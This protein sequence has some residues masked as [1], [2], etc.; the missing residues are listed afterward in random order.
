VQ[1]G[2]DPSDSNI[3]VEFVQLDSGDFC[4]SIF[5]EQFGNSVAVITTELKSEDL[6]RHTWRKLRLIPQTKKEIKFEIGGFATITNLPT[7]ALR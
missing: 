4:I 6:F 5:R 3:F 1:H 2:K 7:F